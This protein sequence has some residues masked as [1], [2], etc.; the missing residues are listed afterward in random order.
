[1]MEGVRWRAGICIMGITLSLRLS[2]ATGGA[3]Q[4]DYVR[5][6]N[7]LE[8]GRRDLMCTGIMQ[9]LRVHNDTQ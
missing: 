6:P 5:A 3:R 7:Q 4:A 9:S 2:L 1:M 8:I